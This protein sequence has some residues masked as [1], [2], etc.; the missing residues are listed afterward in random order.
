[1]HPA[2]TVQQSR[3]RLS[4]RHPVRVEARM[5]HKNVALHGHQFY[6]IVLVIE[7][8]ADHLTLEGVERI[9][10]G[11][12]MV[13]APG[14]THGYARC[15]KLGIIN[16]YYLAEW[17]LADIQALRSIE[18]LVP[19][20]FAS[21]LYHQPPL[22]RIPHVV[23]DRDALAACRAELEDIG[24]HDADTDVPLLYLEACFLKF[25]IVV[26]Q[27]CARNGVS[28]LLRPFRGE[29]RRGL[30]EIESLIATQREFSVAQVAR[31]AGLST[32]HFTR[33]FKGVTGISP[34]EYFQKH[35]IHHV[36]RRL[37]NSEA[38]ITEIA[39]ESGYSDAAHLGRYFKRYQGVTPKAYQRQWR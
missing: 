10:P 32:D 38:S 3:V 37:L 15:S 19:L 6:E 28:S 31:Q 16:V 1:M 35:R 4:S 8:T 11:S 29:V 23:L 24:S 27:A 21:N 14:Q 17:F 39:H 25:L 34:M 22:P 33:L 30:A 13:V 12:A 2:R 9:G 26:G 5:D 7:G 20:F 18:F 36:C